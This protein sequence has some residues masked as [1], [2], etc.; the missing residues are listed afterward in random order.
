MLK[1]IKTVWVRNLLRKI[2][3][4]IPIDFLIEDAIVITDR[5]STEYRI[6]S[7][8][9]GY[10]R[11][12]SDMN[13]GRA[14]M[15]DPKDVVYVIAA[16]PKKVTTPE[17]KLT[18]LDEFERKVVD[19]EKRVNEKRK[20]IHPLWMEIHY[21]NGEI[22]LNVLPDISY[23]KDAITSLDKEEDVRSITVSTSLIESPIFIE[24]ARKSIYMACI[25][26]EYKPKS[27]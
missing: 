25:W 18:T 15:L 16:V 21:D 24:A 9:D 1:N 20:K 11:G 5:C 8:D 7:L 4:D 26:E 10:L 13:K 6:S 17:L 23:S 27:S 19:S 12:S 3:F 14:E 22:Y 2:G